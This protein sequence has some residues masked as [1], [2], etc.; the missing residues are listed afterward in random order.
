MA[1]LIKKPNLPVATA[2]PVVKCGSVVIGANDP[3]T[4]VT[5]KVYTKKENKLLL[6]KLASGALQSQALDRERVFDALY[7]GDGAAGALKP[8]YDPD[9]LFTT[10]LENN[11]LLPCID[12]MITNID[13]TGYEIVS[14]DEDNKEEAPEDQ[15]AKAKAFF[16]QVWPGLSFTTFRCQIRRD[17]EITGNAYIE[18][19]RNAMGDIALLRRLDPTITRM[20]RY[21]DMTHDEK[22][23]SAALDTEVTI[24]MRRRRYVQFSFGKLVY[25]KEFGSSA[26][27]DATNGKWKGKNVN[28]GPGEASYVPQGSSTEFVPANE[29]LHLTVKVHHEVPYGYPRWINQTPSVIG[30]RR[31]EMFNVGF[32]D[33]GGIPP[34]LLLIQ[35]GSSGDDLEK[36]LKEMFYSKGPHKN[37]AAILQVE[38]TEGSLDRPSNVKVTVERFGNEKQKDAM[39][40]LYDAACTKKIKRAF[41]LPSLFLGDTDDFDYATALASYRV[42]EAQVFKP[43]RDLFDE[44][45]NGT[46]MPALFKVTQDK[47]T[48]V[49]RSLPVTAK[50]MEQQI[51]A[52]TTAGS[53][54]WID[55]D[56]AVANLNEITDLE[57]MASENPGAFL[58]DIMGM[59]KD[60]EFQGQQNFADRQTTGM[61][62]EKDKKFQE[63][64]GDKDK[65]FQN[66]QGDKAHQRAIQLAK[67]KPK[68]KAPMR[69]QEIDIL[70]VMTHIAVDVLR[71][72]RKG[73]Q[74]A[75]DCVAFMKSLDPLRLEA[76]GARLGRAMFNCTTEEEVPAAR[77]ALAALQQA[78]GDE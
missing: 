76:F 75:L 63:R 42:A 45:I 72:K 62:A 54:G 66:Q 73:S 11:T 33:A 69:K 14:A 2:K 1:V 18:V 44:M 10:V 17:M 55:P 34:L 30:S 7:A 53:A 64:T 29:I 23:Y 37:I 13:G 40:E 50:D 28:V 25:F 46:L 12:A 19:I 51:L 39:F 35:G 43:E 32:F 60:Q 56:E 70:D 61:M 67:L 77:L 59:D 74:P 52:V 27:L 20:M 31:A 49:F 68:P 24:K 57:M 21:D 9:L 65:Q 78:G 4:T 3:A 5:K 15:V 47:L 48:V 16:D 71:S 38:G 36:A 41:R 22:V 26:Q 8:P 58:P 6:Q